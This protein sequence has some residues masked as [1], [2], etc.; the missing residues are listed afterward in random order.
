ME[1]IAK[2]DPPP[3]DALDRGVRNRPF[4]NFGE[5]DRRRSLGAEEPAAPPLPI[6]AERLSAPTAEEVEAMPFVSVLVP[7]SFTRHWSHATLFKCWKQQTY[8]K[9]RREMLILDTGGAPSPFFTTRCRDRTVRYFHVGMPPPAARTVGGKRNWLAGKARGSVLAAFDDDDI[10]L[11]DYLERMVSVLSCE[12]AGLVKLASWVSFDASGGSLGVF[13]AD[14]D[15][16]WGHHSRRWGYGFSYVYTSALAKAV[17]FPPQDFGE[18]YAFVLASCRAGWRVLQYADE[19]PKACCVHVSHGL[20]TSVV[21]GARPL[22]PPG[23]GGGGGGGGLD[24]HFACAKLSGY[25][26][27]KLLAPAVEH[28]S[29]VRNQASRAGMALPPTA[30]DRLGNALPPQQAHALGPTTQA[31]HAAGAASATSAAGA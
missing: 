23:S 18:D 31:A 7:T 2:H 24:A 12:G 22:E 19:S 29:E 9:D 26:L 4:A 25:P 15:N 6:L 13:E 30:T 3:T 27:R 28:T 5:R 21:R 16:A 1:A 10:Y 14:A 11:P 8:P 20:N 17:P